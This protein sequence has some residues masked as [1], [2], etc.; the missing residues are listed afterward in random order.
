[1]AIPEYT[2][3]FV[4]VRLI[5]RG[6]GTENPGLL[7]S[8]P[9]SSKSAPMGCRDNTEY[10]IK[11]LSQSI[12]FMYIILSVRG[13]TWIIIAY[14]HVC[15][16]SVLFVPEYNTYTDC[17]YVFINVFTVGFPRPFFL[18]VKICSL[19]KL[20]KS[21]VSQWYLYCIFLLA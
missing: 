8:W 12:L 11:N 16:Y 17:S 3:V 20:Q 2:V 13:Q 1:M 14:R 21:Y 5:T 6:S 10:S 4:K 18:F 15:K 7:K 9:Q 19:Y